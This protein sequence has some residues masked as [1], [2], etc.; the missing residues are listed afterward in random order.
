MTRQGLAL[1]FLA[2]ILAQAIVVMFVPRAWIN[3][4][5]TLAGLF[6]VGC[7][8]AIAFV[9]RPFPLR[10]SF[11]MIPLACAVA[12]GALQLAAN[13]TTG[14]A[15]T[16]FAVLI[17]LGN[18]LVFFLALQVGR[19]LAD[20]LLY[21][22]FALC[23]IAVVQYFSGVSRIFWLF[24]TDAPAW[25]PFV[26]RDQYAAFIEM[27]LP[28]ALVKSLGGGPRAMRFAVMAAAM[29]ASVIAGGSRTGAILAT[30]EIVVVWSALASRRRSTTYP[31]GFYL[32]MVVFVCVAGWATLWQ[33]LHD[34]DPLG[35]RP[36]ILAST[37]AMA[38][39]RPFTG[40]GLG[41]FRTVYPAWASIDFG[42]V[43]NHAHND[44]AEWA[45]DGGVPFCLTI[46]LI[47]LWSVRRAQRTLWGIGVVAVFV[48]AIVDFPLH[49]PALELWLFAM[50]GALAAESI[51]SPD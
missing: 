4:T 50:L 2:T 22:A 48:H 32:L 46:I 11:P 47:A 9:I 1:S 10:F 25:G 23:V 40:F 26:N 42:A 6:V 37:V 51:A 18:L 15:E 44:W 16:R 33:R 41:T 36:A 7:A 38:G 29:Y 19:R 39:A 17:W 43:V 21:F 31:T 30:A 12:W 35:G 13:W 28:L 8:W 20:A 5:L 24:P 45:A 14:R 49:V 3:P 27:V 34:P